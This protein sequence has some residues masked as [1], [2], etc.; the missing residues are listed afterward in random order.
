M[1]SPD[2]TLDQHAIATC[3]FNIHDS[4]ASSV[5]F[6]ARLRSTNVCLINYTKDDEQGLFLPLIWVDMYLVM[7]K[8]RDPESPKKTL[9][10]RDQ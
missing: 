5:P 3:A 10:V 7:W 2:H 6:D 4:H 1:L 8:L 9:L